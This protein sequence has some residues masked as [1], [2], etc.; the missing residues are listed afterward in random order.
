MAKASSS[1]AM[2][3]DFLKHT[4]GNPLSEALTSLVVAQPAD[5]IEYIGEALLEYI[6]RMEAET[7]VFGKSC[8]GKRRVEQKQGHSFFCLCTSVRKI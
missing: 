5:P 3:A 4:V 6:K 7:K 2:D 8:S 1:A